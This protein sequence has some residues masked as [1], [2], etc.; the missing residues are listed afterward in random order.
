MRNIV[1]LEFFYGFFH[2]TLRTVHFERNF[3]AWH[4][5]WCLTPQLVPDT[6]TWCLTPNSDTIE[7]PN[8]SCHKKYV[9]G[10][11][12]VYFCGPWKEGFF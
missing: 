2:W 11:R 10:L 12:N 1:R 3:G 5:N 7:T 4:P 8:R 6:P 9:L